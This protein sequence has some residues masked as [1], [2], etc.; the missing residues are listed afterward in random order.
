MNLKR[1]LIVGAVCAV[2]AALL[3]SA[4]TSFTGTRRAAPLPAPR[5]LAVEANGAALAAEIARLHDRLHPTTAPQQPARNLFAFSA[6]RAARPPVAE[7]VVEPVLAAP[8]QSPPPTLRL[9]GIAEDAGPVRTA[10]VSGSGELVLAKEG[11]AVTSRYRVE[12]IA[13][14][15]VDLKDVNDGTTLHLDLK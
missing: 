13:G 9:V 10:I 2:L 8:P 3:S 7:P 4:A 6:T 15:G 5:T 12:H 1:T 14:D 11:D